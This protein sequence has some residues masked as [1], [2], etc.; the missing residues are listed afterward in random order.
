MQPVE[1]PTKEQEWNKAIESH[2]SPERCGSSLQFREAVNTVRMAMNTGGRGSGTPPGIR[3]KKSSFNP[4]SADD[5][6]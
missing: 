6:G 2:F 5:P 3:G 1:V 4:C